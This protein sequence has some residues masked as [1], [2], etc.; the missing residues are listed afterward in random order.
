MI[1]VTGRCVAFSERPWAME[2]R[3]GI[4]RKLTLAD[5]ST[6]FVVKISEEVANAAP[7]A[8]STLSA[9]DDLMDFRLTAEVTLK[10]ENLV[11]TNA[12][13]FRL[14][15]FSKGVT[16]SAASVGSNGGERQTVKA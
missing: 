15:P 6:T 1:A 9:A 11:C 16:L 7:G 12:A 13:F 5:A 8:L 14:E 10:G 2:G 4:T 3:S